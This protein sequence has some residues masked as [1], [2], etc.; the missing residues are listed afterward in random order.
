MSVS[1]N[2]FLLKRVNEANLRAVK[3]R[4][5]PARRRRVP[6]APG[7][8]GIVLLDGEPIRRK[9][10]RDYEK[11]L[12]DLD[13]AKAEAERF[14]SEDKPLFAQW[15]NSN[16]GALLTEIRE[17]Q[18]KLFHAQGLV[19]EVQ[20]E[21]F[22][23]NYRSINKAYKNV[24]HRREHPEEREEEVRQAEEEEA[25][26]RK[27]F[28]EAFKKTEDEF[29]KHFKG[30]SDE[31]N[32]PPRKAEAKKG[33]RLK[34]LYRNLV[35]LLHPDKGAKRSKK[36]IEWWHQTQDAYQTGNVEQLELILTLV[37]MENRG[38]KDATVSVLAQLTSEFKKSLKALKRKI[39]VLKKEL[40]WNFSLLPDCSS[41]FVRVRN[42]LQADRD[43]ML[44]LLQKYEQQIRTWETAPASAPKRAR[45]RR[46]AY[47]D[48]EWF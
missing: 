1:S 3:F 29:W 21:F 28:E 14:E 12:R 11:V 13:V 27:E 26:F 2:F 35:R 30:D 31:F 19:E 10:R 34:D 40:A 46:G 45:A 39:S 41:L 23:G 37:E 22:V 20:D 15:V 16:F 17:L 32:P 33:G 38:S 36:E 4:A 42:E 47:Q 18:E 8:W 9:A 48:E 43:R 5:Q 6:P 24:M 25:E 7:A 44:W